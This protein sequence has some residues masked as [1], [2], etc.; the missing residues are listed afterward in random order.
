MRKG[1]RPRKSRA[2][3]K[4]HQGHPVDFLAVSPLKNSA[5][6]IK[7]LREA[8]H[9]LAPVQLRQVAEDSAAIAEASRAVHGRIPSL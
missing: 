5:L 9:N 2:P 4:A 8:R 3:R 6:Q 1:K 7:R